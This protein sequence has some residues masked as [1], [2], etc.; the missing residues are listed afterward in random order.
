MKAATL[1]KTTSALTHG[2]LQNR[3]QKQ[4]LDHF[5]VSNYISGKGGHN[6]FIWV[7]LGQNKIQLEINSI[8]YLGSRVSFPWS[9]YLQYFKVTD[10]KELKIVS[11]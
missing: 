7:C 10:L 5:S 3:L 9:F 6:R 4:S 2:K 1:T 11:Y 8:I